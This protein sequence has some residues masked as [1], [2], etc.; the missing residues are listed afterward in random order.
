MDTLQSLQ[1]A[2]GAEFSDGALPPL[3]FGDLAA[4]Y[5][6]AQESAVLVD[7]RD[8]GRLELTDRDR[9]A[10]LNRISTNAVAD[11]PPGTGRAT[12]LTTPIGRI[13]DR[14]VLHNLDEERTLVRTGPG[15]GARVTAYLQRN[16]FFRDRMQIR[17]V[18]GEW[19]QLVLYGPRA[20]VIARSLSPDLPD[21]ALHHVYATR[22]GSDQLLIVAVD[23]PG[24]PAA[25]LIVPA[26]RAAELWQTVLQ[27]GGRESVRASGLAVWELLRVEAG[28]PGPAE[29]NEEFIPLEA[30]LWADV[31]FNKGC[32]TGQEII[33]RM[34]SRG[35]LARTLVTVTL[36]GAATPGAEWT[37]DGRRQGLLTS[38]A[39]QPDGAWIGLGYVRPELATVGQPLQLPGDVTATIRFAVD[40]LS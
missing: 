18:T 19:A 30:G 5:R 39:Q 37:V 32:Y 11:L 31:S 26:A 8:E 3:H 23:P 12:V 9:L 17:D 10:I 36:S 35:K 4:E 2:Q 29:L 27:A 15:R 6:A 38:V 14:L 25:G 20:W 1:A 13:I 24:V 28:L 16:V 40:R 33:A 34:E 21:L 7:R 22:F